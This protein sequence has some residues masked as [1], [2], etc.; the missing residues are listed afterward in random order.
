MILTTQPPSTGKLD[1]F[2][3]EALDRDPNKYGKQ[4]YTVAHDRRFAAFAAELV[5]DATFDY[6]HHSE[7]FICTYCNVPA[8]NGSQTG[9]PATG[10][11]GKSS[12]RWLDSSPEAVTK[13]QELKA[14]YDAWLEKQSA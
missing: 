2:S 5:P 14:Q 3:Q 8:F 4:A 10:T 9:L 11:G 6:L 12:L 13:W 1:P 7:E